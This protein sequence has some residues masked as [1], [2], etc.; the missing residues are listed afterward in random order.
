MKV[1]EGTHDMTSN[2]IT[3]RPVTNL[4]LRNIRSWYFRVKFVPSELS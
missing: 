2:L 3:I 1:R 4:Y